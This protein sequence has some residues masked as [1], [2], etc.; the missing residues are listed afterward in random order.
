MAI[1]RSFFFDHV[2]LYLFD[3]KL[4]Q[5]QV[6]GLDAILDYWGNKMEACDDRWL[7]YALAT[8]H[9]ETDRSMQPIKEYGS[10][11]YFMRMYDCSG[12]R[13]LVAKNLGNTHP[14]DGAKYYGRG[15]VQLTGRRNYTD[16]SKRLDHDLVGNPDLALDPAIAT[17]ILFEGMRQGT[18]TGR[19]FADYFNPQK[20]DWL[21]ARRIINW[22]DKANLIEGYGKRYYGGISY[23]T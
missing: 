10:T 16:W 22:I 12:G 23:T 13:P 7:A 9:H 8:A 4:K 19:K 20:E 17:R 6:Q 18:F 14:G 2:R 3:G 11:A 15:Y 21:N 5:S 1:N